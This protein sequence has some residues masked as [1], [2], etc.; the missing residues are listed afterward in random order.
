[1][2]SLLTDALCEIVCC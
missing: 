2:Y 1:M